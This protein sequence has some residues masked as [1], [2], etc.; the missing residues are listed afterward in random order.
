MMVHQERRAWYPAGSYNKSP[1]YEL[2]ITVR[3]SA[4]S[5]RVT[6]I[7]CLRGRTMEIF[8]YAL[9]QNATARPNRQSLLPCWWCDHALVPVV[10]AASYERTIQIFLV[11]NQHNHRVSGMEINSLY[12]HEAGCSMPCSCSCRV[13]AILWTIVTYKIHIVYVQCVWNCILDTYNVYV[14]CTLAK[15]IQ[16]IYFFMRLY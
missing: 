1:A 14:I 15:Y 11:A 13:S 2:N 10:L 8:L 6:A 9:R 16:Y 12:C 4:E 5:C 7:F 3:T